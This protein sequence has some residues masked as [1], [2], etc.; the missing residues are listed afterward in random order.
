MRRRE[1]EGPEKLMC[2]KEKRFISEISEQNPKPSSD[3][4]NDTELGNV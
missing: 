4:S 2:H 3:T 1:A